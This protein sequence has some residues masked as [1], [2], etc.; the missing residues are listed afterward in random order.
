MDGF[1][2]RPLHVTL[3]KEV[4]YAIADTL[5][6]RTSRRK[7]ILGE[8]TLIMGIINVTPD[9][10]SDGGRFFDTGRAVA[11]ALELVAAGADI[12]DVG[13]ESTRPGAQPV[14]ADEEL[15]RK[16]L[17]VP[18]GPRKL[19]VL[20][21]RGMCPACSRW[22]AAWTSSGTSSSHGGA[23]RANARRVRVATRRSR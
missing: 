7:M 11:H 10:F 19:G 22:S 2:I 3:E 1:G 8:R 5:P 13:G 21:Q 12:L 20:D 4:S 23:P 15:A 16:D 6:L 18:R 14:P 17:A 9:S